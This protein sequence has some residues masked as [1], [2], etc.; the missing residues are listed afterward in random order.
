MSTDL[1]HRR[2]VLWGALSLGIVSSSAWGFGSSSKVDI[3]ELDVG[4]GTVVRPNAWRRLLYDV[5]AT[6]SVEIE[7]RAVR[8]APGDPSLFEHPF[9]VLCGNRA[10]AMPSEKGLEQ[11]SRYLSYG[12][13]LLCDDASAGSDSGFYDSVK[14][15]M[16]ALFPTRSLTPIP[17]DHSIYRSFFL[18]QRPMG[19][20][21]G[22]PTLRA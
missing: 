8:L 16:R 9:A 22:M 17:T 5:E 3:A 14:R 19:R 1:V 18:I 20:L 10:F 4:A 7:P 11:L 12:G 13:F 6:T 15:L 2:Q 21:I